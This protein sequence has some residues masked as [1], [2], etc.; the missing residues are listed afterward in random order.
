MSHQTIVIREQDTTLRIDQ[1][2]VP[3]RISS[4]IT[5]PVGGDPF[6]FCDENGGLLLT[7]DANGN[8]ISEKGFFELSGQAAPAVSPAGK[9]RLY[10]DSGT[11]KLLLSED[12]GAYSSIVDGLGDGDVVGPGSSTDD[13]LVRWDTATGKLIQDSNALLNDA[14]DLTLVG[15][16]SL[17]KFLDVTGIAAPALSPA[18]EARLYFDSGTN[19][20]RLSENG[21]AFDDLVGAG[22]D[23]VGPGSATDDALVRWDAAT[24]KLVQ[25]SNALLNDAGDLTLVGSQ[26]LGKFL[27]VTGIAAPALSPGGES[28]LYFDSTSN[29]LRISENG[30]AFVDVIGGAGDVVGPA[31]ATDNALVRF[32]GTTGKLVQNSLVTIDD[33]GVITAAG[34]LNFTNNEADSAT[35]VGF[36]HHSDDLDRDTFTAGALLDKWTD[37]NDDSIMELAPNGVVQFR[38]TTSFFVQ[39]FLFPSNSSEGA[40]SFGRSG[41]NLQVTTTSGFTV[42]G[43]SGMTVIAMIRTPAIRPNLST[44]LLISNNQNPGTPGNEDI[45]ARFRTGVSAANDRDVLRCRNSGPEIPPLNPIGA[46]NQLEDSFTL[47]FRAGYDSDPTAGFTEAFF[48][49]EIQHVMLTGDASPTSEV[50]FSI[51]GNARLTLQSAAPTAYTRNATVVEDRTLLASASATTINNNNVIAALIADLQATGLIG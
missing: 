44:N 5:L 42:N 50:V 48:D 23:V 32:D 27:D 40:Q 1:V 2:V 35:A 13:A 22:G 34:R 17:G 39:G 9:M 16:Q 28:R 46:D 25:D 18:G 3:S 30:G 19:K 14:G 7:I 24:G 47:R 33:A 49:A 37:A 10:F 20:L 26:S 38:G 31:S 12:G 15:S 45:I 21:G 36:L 8:I 43:N 41:N 51:D 11:N 4:K 6:T 29:K